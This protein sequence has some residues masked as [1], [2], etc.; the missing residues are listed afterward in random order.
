MGWVSVN[1][2]NVLI[3]S[4]TLAYW[5][6]AYAGTGTTEDPYL[7]NLTILGTIS[8]GVWHGS[9][10]GTAYGGTGNT[11]FTKN[12]LIYTNTATKFAST[13]SIYAS[14]TAITING[15]SAPANSGNFQVKG[16][17]TM[18]TILPEST[19]VYDLGQANSATGNNP[20]NGIRWSHLYIGTA[21]TYGAYGKPIY[22]NAG[23][24]AATYPVQYTTWTIPSGSSSVTIEKAG[25]YFTDT[26]VLSI[27]VTSGE[28]KLPGALTWNTDTADQLTIATTGNVSDTVSGYVLTARADYI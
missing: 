24:P 18:Q 23:A 16:T 13:S 28:D 9:T 20:D 15:T 5:N 22:W 8:K 12:R 27:V 4:N 7:S 6:G 11:S 3:T 21:D 2:D 10:I 19:N 25:K 26:Y 17:S 14:T 1:D